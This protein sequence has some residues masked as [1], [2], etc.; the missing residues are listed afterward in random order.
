MEGNLLVFSF[1]VSPFWQKLLETLA[2]MHKNFLMILNLNTVM[3]PKLDGIEDRIGFE[4]H[5]LPY[6]E[7]ELALR[8]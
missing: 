4:P 2:K 3:Y 5:C 7:C 1:C 6:L 8:P